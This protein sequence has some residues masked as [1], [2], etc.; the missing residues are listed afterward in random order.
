MAN[1]F[2]RL[3]FETALALHS[4]REPPVNQN[5]VDDV[6]LECMHR[7]RETHPMICSHTFECERR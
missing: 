6:N 4:G 5:K 2:A 1:E 7:N 3:S